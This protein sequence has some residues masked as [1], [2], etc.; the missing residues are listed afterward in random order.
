MADLI[1]GTVREKVIGSYK[2]LYAETKRPFAVRTLPYHS[3]QSLEFEIVD[4]DATG[5]YAYAVADKQELDFFHYGIGDRIEL[6]AET[7]HKATRADTNLSKGKSTNGANDYVIEQLSLHVRGIKVAYSSA[8]GFTASNG[9]PS[10]ANVVRSLTGKGPFHDPTSIATPA[11]CFNPAYLEQ[12]IYEA[13]R[14]WC[15]LM[16]E[17]DQSGMRPIG[18]SWLLGQGGASSY[19]RAN[20][21]PSRESRLYIEEGYLWARDGE[22]DSDFTARLKLEEPVV[23][24]ITAITVPGN[25][26]ELRVP[27]KLWVELT[28]TAWGFE[29]GLPSSN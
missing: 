7:D 19:L 28:L 27:T 22:P 12:T 29:I 24:P 20:G 17:F 1:I 26:S 13:V 14:N 6:S 9:T 3:T 25:T 15:S 18:G 16:L 23:V 8:V 2:A 4:T 21:V 10:N 11:E 5:G